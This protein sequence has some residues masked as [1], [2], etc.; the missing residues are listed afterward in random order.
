[1]DAGKPVLAFKLGRSDSGREVAATHTGSIAGADASASAFFR[2]HG[3]V[4]VEVFEALFETAQMLLGQRPPA[5]RRVGAVTVSGGAAAMVVDRLGLSGIALSPPPAPMVERLAARRIRIGAGPLIDLP[6][7]RADGGAY[8][9]VLETLL[10]SN[11]CDVVLAV[12]GSDAAYLPDSVRSRILAAKRGSKP[13]AVFV[14][15]R[16]EG[17]LALLQEHG[18]AAFRTPE[19]CADAIRAYCEWRAPERPAHIDPADAAALR[20]AIDVAGCGRLDEPTAFRLLAAIGIPTA[21][22]RVIAS[23][24]A[25]GDL[26]IGRA[27]V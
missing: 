10:A 23:A 3:I 27:H 24:D 4:R 16:A 21:P 5:S 18:V 8:A 2:A 17:A 12:Q 26:Q 14:G 25:P 13:L 15:P 22:M 9:I 11:H 1:F 19:A 6:M 20:R 7:G